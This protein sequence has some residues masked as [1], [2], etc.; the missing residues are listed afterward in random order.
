MNDE[1][2]KYIR[3]FLTDMD[4]TIYLGSQLLP[5][6]KR[7]MDLL[8]AKGLEYYFLTN[9]SSRS[10][11]EYAQKLA[12]LGLPTPEERIFTSGEATA[13]YLQKHYSGA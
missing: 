2:L 7:W 4:G 5:G 3:C 11:V 9:N 8:Q 12:Q 13:I 6:A 1:K 10:R